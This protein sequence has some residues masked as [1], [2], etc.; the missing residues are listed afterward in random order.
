[1]KTWQKDIL[2]SL[3]SSAAILALIT[4]AAW[5]SG[6]EFG[7]CGPVNA[8]GL[9]LLL[10]YLPGIVMMNLVPFGEELVWVSAFLFFASTIA[11]H[12][13]PVWMLLKIRRYPWN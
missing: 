3:A 1:M 7:P 11:C 13:I 4:W 2:I 9:F 12:A 5:S 8:P 6:V 10:V